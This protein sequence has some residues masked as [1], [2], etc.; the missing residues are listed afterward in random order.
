MAGNGESRFAFAP[1]LSVLLPSG[2]VAKGRSFGALGIQTNLP[3]SIVLHRR[4]VS[5][6]NAGATLVPNAQSADHYRATTAGHNLGQSMVLIVH[7]RFNFLV[8]TVANRFQS[9]LSPGRTEWCRTAYVSPGVRWA[10]NFKS[11]LQIVP[12]V[13]FPLGVGPSSG[14]RGCSFISVSSTR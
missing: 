9:V 14:E 4:L 2:D 8:E 6:W 1:R 10:Y 12:G 7:P 3:V 13:A 5:H 11:G